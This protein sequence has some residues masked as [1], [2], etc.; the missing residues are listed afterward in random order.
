MFVH[1]F[2]QLKAKETPRKISTG[3]SRKQYNDKNA[4]E[5]ILSNANSN[6]SRYVNNNADIEENSSNAS[7]DILQNAS[8][9]REELQSSLTSHSDVD[10]VELEGRR[11]EFVRSSSTGDADDLAAGTPLTDK[12]K[13]KSLKTPNTNRGL[14]P[15]KPRKVA[16]PKPPRGIMP[17]RSDFSISDSDSLGSPERGFTSSA[18]QLKP[19]YN[20]EKSP[21]TRTKGPEVQAP[22]ADRDSDVGS[23]VADGAMN[24]HNRRAKVSL[25]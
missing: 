6:E 8:I 1:L 15:T 16:P 21:E 20:T 4:K 22:I 13:S 5:N 10:K 7:T 17:H 25:G 3:S 18:K 2:Q 24:I 14:A 23:D 19:D 12:L 11:G 9:L